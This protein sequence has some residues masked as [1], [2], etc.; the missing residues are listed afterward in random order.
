MV[1]QVTRFPVSTGGG[2]YR[3][4]I[5]HS[6]LLT[7]GEGLA[8]A[9]PGAVRM[10]GEPVPGWVKRSHTAYIVKAKNELCFACT[11]NCVL[12]AYRSFLV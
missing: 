1:G 4:G 3:R 6:T 7:W 10:L 5:L 9:G 2:G 12:G 11:S 8:D